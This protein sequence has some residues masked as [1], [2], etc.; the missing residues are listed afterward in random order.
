MKRTVHVFKYVLLCLFMTTSVHAQDNQKNQPG[1]KE[2]KKGEISFKS[3]TA[4]NGDVSYG[5]RMD[6]L[7]VGPNMVLHTDGSTTYQN[8]NKES[9]IDGVVIQMKKQEGT[10]ELYTYRH[11][12]KNGPAFKIANGK[13]EWKEQF[14]DDNRDL[15]G[16]V[17]EPP[18]K[19]A[20]I[21]GDGISGFSMEKYDES[22]ALGYF[23]WGYRF[24][25][26]IHVWENSEWYSY[27]GQYLGGGRNGFGVLF[28]TN[29]DKYIGYWDDNYKEGLG[30]WLDKDGNIT[31]KGHYKGGELEIAL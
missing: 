6:G 17:V 13:V 31:E 23:K 16:F 19:Y 22:Y 9:K 12:K 1:K 7:I 18:G 28:Y 10:I 11:S 3:F 2:V 29:G 25:P 4:E 27:Y 21:K 15:N 24:S 20:L 26:M 5:F 8:Y 30:F 14:K